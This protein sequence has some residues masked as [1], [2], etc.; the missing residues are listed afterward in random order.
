MIF[1]KY[2]YAKFSTFIL[3]EFVKLFANYFVYDFLFNVSAYIIVRQKNISLKILRN[4][5][6]KVITNKQYCTWGSNGIYILRFPTT[7]VNEISAYKNKQNF[8]SLSTDDTL[9][10]VLINANDCIITVRYSI[11]TLIFIQNT[12][13]V[14]LRSYGTYFII[15]KI[16]KQF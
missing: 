3:K 6:L 8:E 13:C 12:E 14:F 5:N 7:S 11:Q 4:A 2:L 15:F 9:E 1:S 10:S 16:T